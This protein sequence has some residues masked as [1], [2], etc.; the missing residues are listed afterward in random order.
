MKIDF[1]KNNGLVPA[2]IQDAQTNKV[3]MLGYM[4]EESYNRTIQSGKVTFFSRSRQQLWMKGEESGN[5]LFLKE[6]LIDCDG[7]TLLIK[8][9]PV[10]PVCHKG[11]D[12]CFNEI[13]SDTTPFL[14]ELERIIKNRKSHPVP[15]SYTCKLFEEGPNKIAQKVGEE[16]TELIVEAVSGNIDRIKEET[17]D[18]LYHLLVLLSDKNITLNDIM[19]VLSNRHKK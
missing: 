5:F 10:G 11:G 9:N 13:N 8:A 17:A 18:L 19:T 12:T 14:F 3:L 15:K 1:D 6:I 2:I 7:D 4:N 16:T